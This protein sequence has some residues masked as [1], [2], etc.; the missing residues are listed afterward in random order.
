M[1]KLFYLLLVIVLSSCSKFTDGGLISKADKRIVN[2]WKMQ[3][4]LLD[5]VDQTSTLL[6]SGLEEVYKEDGSYMR[7]YID[8]DGLAFEEIGDWELPDKSES[9]NIT[10]VSSLE[11][12]DQHSTVSSN[13]YNV[14]KM[15]K[16]EFW[17]EFT[18]GGAT[19]E[20]RFVLL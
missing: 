2:S 15:T 1:K 7:S 17:Y 3:S 10:S 20:F 18:N 19:H 6:I 13:Q 16:D 12:S 11:L 14:K 4:Y 9:I 8:K 5:G